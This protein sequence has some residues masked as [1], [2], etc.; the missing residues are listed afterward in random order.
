MLRDEIVLSRLKKAPKGLTC[1]DFKP[2]LHY[3]DAIMNLRSQ[4]HRIDMIMEEDSAMSRQIGRYYYKG[5]TGEIQK[6]K[7][8]KANAKNKARDL[9]FNLMM[10]KN[11]PSEV[12]MKA[13]QIFNL[14]K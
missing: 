6:P 2:G 3:K 4:G 12:R 13:T 7:V 14:L 10:N 5:K 1:Y 8:K 9:S 11:W